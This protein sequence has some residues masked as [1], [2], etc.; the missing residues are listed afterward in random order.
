MAKQAMRKVEVTQGRDGWV[1]KTKSGRS[2]ATGTTKAK[3][4]KNA[5][6]K[7]RNSTRPVTLRIRGRDGR[8]QEEWT[9][10][11]SADPRSSQG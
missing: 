1:A 8:I 5:A 3:V 10:P 4:V 9:Y 6:A 7:A 11:R 2:F